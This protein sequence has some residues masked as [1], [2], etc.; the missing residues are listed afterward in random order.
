MQRKMIEPYILH[1]FD[2]D[3]YGE[4]LRLV[5]TGYIRPEAKF[6]GAN[7]LQDLKSAIANDVVVTDTTLQ[8]EGFLPTEDERAFLKGVGVATDDDVPA[9]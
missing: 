3:F 9:L 7:W 8:Q 2:S 6:E 5:L 1:S 4:P